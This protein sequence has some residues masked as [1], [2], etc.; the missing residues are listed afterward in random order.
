MSRRDLGVL[1]SATWGWDCLEGGHWELLM[2]S[3][4]KVSVG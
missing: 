2:C 4:G 1:R 3:R